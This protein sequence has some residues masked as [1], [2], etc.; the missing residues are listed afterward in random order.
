[1]PCKRSAEKP[2]RSIGGMMRRLD[3]RGVAA[4]EFCIVAAAFFI[5]VFAIIDLGRYALTMQSLRMLADAGARKTMIG[6]PDFSCYTDAAIA[7]G[8]PTCSGDPLPSDAQKQAVAPF[9]YSR[10]G[11]LKP[12]L[13]ATTGANAV[14]VTASQPGF[15]MLTPHIWPAVFNAPSAS[16]EI[17]F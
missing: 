11:T 4:L 1:M 3:Q 15:K 8:T 13:N 16:T 9:L 2:N 12:T 14:T 10:D 5:L 7:H 6:L 17:P